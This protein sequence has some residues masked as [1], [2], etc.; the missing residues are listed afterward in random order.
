MKLFPEK[1]SNLLFPRPSGKPKIGK[2]TLLL[3]KAGE[4]RVASELLLRGIDASLPLADTGIDLILTSGKRIQ[5]KCSRERGCERGRHFY[6]FNF[7]EGLK[8]G[9][10]KRGKCRPHKLENV[11][12][13]ILW[14]IDHDSFFI[15]PAEEVR[16]KQSVTITVR[17]KTNRFMKKED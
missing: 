14:A 17:C 3:G 4:L 10:K 16:G 8:R 6:V 9:E 13:I 15:I 7:R 2:E 5:V 1:N 11:D 12:F